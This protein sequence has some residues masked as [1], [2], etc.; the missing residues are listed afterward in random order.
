VRLRELRLESL[1]A[2]ANLNL[3]LDAGWNVFVGANGAGKTTLLEAAY[4]LS[5]AR[6][7]RGGPKDVLVQRG[8]SGYSVFGRVARPEHT[9]GLGLSRR[10]G[11]LEARVNGAGVPV[12][13]LLLRIA[14]AC[15]EP[16]SHELISGPS[17]N[18]RRFLDWGVFHVEHDFLPVWRSFQR[19]LRQRNALLRGGPTAADLEPWDQE[20]ARSGASLSA[21]RARYFG[22]FARATASMLNTLL[23]EL[24]EPTLTLESGWRAEG[25]P[26]ELLAASR[27]DDLRRGFTTRGPHRA[28]WSIAFEHAPRREHLSRGQEKLCALACILAQ[29]RVFADARGEWPV[30]CIDDLASELDGP[31]Q[32]VLVQSLRAVDAQILVTGTHVPESLTRGGIEAAMFH[33]EPGRAVRLL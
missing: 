8:A 22:S 17:D 16:G 11:V 28:D 7:F 25:D 6:S 1:R 13:D 20:L 24:G 5:H 9:D 14:V 19:A 12:A 10:G 4:L 27:E 26:L 31:H 3:E 33:V 15:F 18:R 29:A 21:M 2:F 32:E 30:L 23:P